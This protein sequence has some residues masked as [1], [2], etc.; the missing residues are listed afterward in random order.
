MPFVLLLSQLLHPPED[1]EQVSS[2][3]QLRSNLSSVE[4]T[5]VFSTSFVGTILV[6][7]LSGSFLKLA[8]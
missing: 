1:D 7:Q 3:Q 6:E 4:I 8:G 5:S 2:S